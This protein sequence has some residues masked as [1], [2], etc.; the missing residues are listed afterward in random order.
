[1]SL[2]VAEYN[3]DLYYDLTNEKHQSNKISKN[4]TWEIIDKTPIPLFKRYNLIS[5]TIPS[6]V[7]PVLNE[8]KYEEQNP[9]ESFFSKL[10]NIKVKEDKLIAKVA[11]ITWFIPKI[12]HIILIVHGGKGSAKSTFLTMIKSIV[13]PAKPSLY[14]T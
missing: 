7:D 9:L 8:G 12:P 6:A 14:Y 5:Q 10:T 4:G 1:L 3:G 2:R 13:D 11:L